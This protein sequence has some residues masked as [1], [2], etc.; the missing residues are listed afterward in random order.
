MKL[1]FAGTP[2]FSASALRAIIAAGHQVVLVLTQPDRPSGRGMVLHP[3]PV[4]ALALASG[5]EVYQPQTLKD[6]A[7]R[8]RLRAVGAE[9]MIVA[10]YGLILPQQVLDL[11]RFGC[12]NIHASLLPRWRGAAPIQRAILAGDTETGVCIM[13]MEAGLDTGPVLHSESLPIAEDDTAATLHDKLAVLGARLI[14]EALQRLPL[15]PCPQPENG[16]SYA[17]KIEKAEAWLDWRLPALQLARQVRA[18]NP[19]PGAATRLQGSPIKVW[20]AEMTAATGAPGV[21]AASD[22]NGIVVTCGQGALR[23]TGLQKAGGKR[24][25]VAQFLAGTALVPGS[26]FDPAS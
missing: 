26:A 8:E 16:V 23:L 25:S 4:K 21:I 17:A 3:S 13:Q 9:A 11:P 5:I 6:A 18:F 24:L 7:A 1:V 19:F 22:R 2:E 12:I 14:V 15:P 20:Q 10:A